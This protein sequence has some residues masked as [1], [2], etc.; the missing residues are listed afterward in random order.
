MDKKR[1]ARF[2]KTFVILNQKKLCSNLS[3]LY[4]ST[5]PIIQSVKSYIQYTEYRLPRFLSIEYLD[6]LGITIFKNFQHAFNELEED[7]IKVGS[8][9]DHV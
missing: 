8:S 4:F 3:I 9:N 6:I 5:A 2:G 7:E 1:F